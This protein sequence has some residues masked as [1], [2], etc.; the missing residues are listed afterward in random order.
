[1]ARNPRSPGAYAANPDNLTWGGEKHGGEGPTDLGVDALSLRGMDDRAAPGGNNAEV[2][3]TRP[4]RLVLVAAAVALGCKQESPAP[5]TTQAQA[6]KPPTAGELLGRPE[7][8][9]W[10]ASMKDRDQRLAWFR[11]ARFGMFVH[12]GVY[13]HAGGVWEGK[14]VEGYAEHLQRKAKIPIAVYREKL[15]GQFNPTGFDAD[16]WIRTLKNAGMGYLIIT[17]KHHDGLAMYD[18]AV[19]DYNV[20][21]ATPWKRDPMRELKEACKR[22]GV[23]FGFYYSQAWEWG[24]P[25]SPG[26]D[27]EFDN[28]G[29]DKGLHGGPRWY[30]SNPQLIPRVRRYVDGKVIPQVRELIAKYDPD[31]MWFD[32]PGRL[33]PEENLRVLEAARKAKPTLV[34][35]S[36]ITQGVPGGP[37][38][39]FGDY[40]STTD[41]PAEFPPH[42]GDWEAIPTTNESYGW[43]REDHS[44]KP[45]AHFIQLLAKAAARGGNVLLNVGPMGNG[46]IDPKDVAI[47]EGVGTWMKANGESIRGTTRTPLAAQAWG[48]STRKG[49]TLYLHVLNWPRK[50][51]LVV[52]GLK[53]RVA[54]AY[55]LADRG[56][57]PLKVAPQAAGAPDVTIA[58]PP[59][60]PDPADTVVV[61]ELEGEVATDPVRLLGVDVASDTLRAFDG[62]LRGEGLAFGAGKSRDAHVHR[63]TRLDQSVRWPVRLREPAT[64]DVAVSY[65]A[66]KKSA[67]GTFVVKVADRSLKGSVEPGLKA[68]VALGRVTLEPGSFDVTVEGTKIAGDELLRLRAVTLTPVASATAARR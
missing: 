67:G 6:R 65:D 2:K 39:H 59:V 24:H 55:L 10:H 61:A 62:Q 68:P 48:E 54:R 8:T 29:G 63:W 58:I 60:A 47:L 12:W 41:K 4:F 30:D 53:S 49:N 43:H 57:K 32:T 46:K 17:A 26:N 22:H 40:F 9:W 1:V 20:V 33:P 11:E 44:H 37:P 25:D 31:I 18:S 3:R 16:E 35:N 19:S 34:V 38:A 14:P 66:E 36:R 13:A 7:M 64:Y 21:K 42:E 28:P 51:K 56:K 5:A 15:A 45:P 23:R 50:G 52:G 27:W